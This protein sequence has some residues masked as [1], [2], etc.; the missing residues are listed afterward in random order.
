MPRS[1]I[2]ADRFSLAIPRFA[3]NEKVSLRLSTVGDL[4]TEGHGAFKDDSHEGWRDKRKGVARVSTGDGLPRGKVFVD[5][6]VTARAPSFHRVQLI[7]IGF[8]QAIHCQCFANSLFFK[9]LNNWLNQ[10]RDQ[11]VAQGVVCGKSFRF[12]TS[13]LQRC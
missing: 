7:S 6:F 2:D 10:V 5:N 13:K 11:G 4:R 1:Q 12:S 9:N 8:Q 3:S